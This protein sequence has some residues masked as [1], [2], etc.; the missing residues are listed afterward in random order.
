LWPVRFSKLRDMRGGF[1][2][3]VPSAGRAGLSRLGFFL[4]RFFL[5]LLA[6]AALLE[7]GLQLASL[8]A[9][10]RFS[11][12]IPISTNAFR[13][14]CLGESTTA[15][16]LQGQRDISW[17]AQ[18]EEILNRRI[19]GRYFQVVN[20]GR[21]GTNTSLILAKLPYYL[22]RYRPDL[23]IS[24]LGVN[25]DKWYGIATGR[26]SPW[27]QAALSLKTYKLVRHLW[28]YSRPSNFPP[29]IP[30]GQ[31]IFTDQCLAGTEQ[32]RPAE[33]EAVC[34]KAL[35][36][37]PRNPQLLL[38]LGKIYR[39]R[40]KRSEERQI[41]EDLLRVAPYWDQSYVFLGAAYKEVD[42]LADAE[43]IGRLALR[44]L[45]DNDTPLRQLASIYFEQ[46]RMSDLV[47]LYKKSLLRDGMAGARL[48]VIVSS[49]VAEPQERP[50]NRITRS[51]YNRIH[52]ILRS[53]S[54]PLVAM[55]YPRE[56]LS[57]LKGLFASTAAITFVENKDNFR[58]ELRR[59]PYGGIFSD[60]FQPLWGHCTEFGNQLIAENLADR[61]RRHGL[62]ERR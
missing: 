48:E 21:V 52:E 26:D 28:E 4:G 23:V 37:H 19:P 42:R 54:I 53:R 1:I 60:R 11:R 32:D 10:W 22:D 27:R 51:N 41:F 13:I 2:C 3:S 17:P 5:V 16:S 24:M 31:D 55:Q 18:L 33:L 9:R 36:V 8:F 45:A 46:G 12:E 30:E 20:K 38:K 59:K 35:R 40:G 49:D 44:R 34:R 25:D 50:A 15:A 43:R 14:L 47:D 62:L 6:A 56:S 7:A 61:L 58:A 39:A 57:S 29:S